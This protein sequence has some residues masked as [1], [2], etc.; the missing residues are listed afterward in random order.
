MSFQK[1]SK[2]QM[3]DVSEKKKH[4]KSKPSFTSSQVKTPRRAFYHPLNSLMGHAFADYNATRGK[5][6]FL[7][8]GTCD[9]NDDSPAPIEVAKVFDH[10]MP[11][12]DLLYVMADCEVIIFESLKTDL[13]FLEAVISH[14]ETTQYLNP[15]TV[16]LMS[17]P[18]IWYETK[19]SRNSFLDSFENLP[20]QN[21][22]KN[23]PKTQKRNKLLNQEP[24]R[25][26]DADFFE[27]RTLPCYELHR[28]IENRIYSLG[29]SNPSVSGSIILPGI[30]FGRGEDDFYPFFESLIASP[31]SPMIII[32]KGENCIPVI[33]CMDMAERMF[34]LL[35]GPKPLKSFYVCSNN[36]RVTQKQLFIEF[37]KVTGMEKL[38]ESSSY[39][40]MLDPNYEILTL[41][42][43]LQ[44]SSVFCQPQ[45]KTNKSQSLEKL[46]SIPKLESNQIISFTEHFNRILGEFIKFRSV[47][48]TR[49][50][51]ICPDIIIE[52]NELIPSLKNALEVDII[53]MDEVINQLLTTSSENETLKLEIE[54]AIEAEREDQFMKQ[55]EVYNEAKKQKKKNI[56]PP[57]KSE[58]KVDI[59]YALKEETY[60]KIL[61]SILQKPKYKIR[62]FVLVNAI[63]DLQ[64]APS[65]VQKIQQ[66]CSFDGVE[67]TIFNFSPTKLQTKLNEMEGQLKAN[68]KSEVLIHSIEQTRKM[69][70]DLTPLAHEVNHDVYGD[71]LIEVVFSDLKI[72]VE[73]LIKRYKERLNL[74]DA[75]EE[76]QTQIKTS[77]QS[78]DSSKQPSAEQLPNK[79]EVSTLGVPL[80]MPSKRNSKMFAESVIPKVKDDTLEALNEEEAILNMKSAAIKQYLA[81]NVLP[82]ITEG[83]IEICKEKPEDPV[84]FLI[85]FLKTKITQN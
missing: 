79:S 77:M 1:N 11:M 12:K 80:T 18:L 49:M 24:S 65:F 29:E 9:Q 69:L 15:K 61:L 27:R 23:D 54:Q 40:H 51:L 4:Y 43:L 81:D 7:I 20:P 41:N 46:N 10:N 85:E 68:P 31:N 37:C 75:N 60:F 42:M 17:H 83:I 38:V 19:I 32:G 45:L 34:Y 26:T 22:L 62:G 2:E 35:S 72:D 28:L 73:I 13:E 44:S 64:R 82:D 58:I 55:T 63:S 3:E 50:V 52:N 47:A 71:G 16:I 21:M 57:V 36:E 59:F 76:G 5:K 39:E 33:H 74:I 53:R 78:L 30:I 66:E 56:L 6:E 14:F 70:D 25:I 67:V 48:L 84:K 8:V